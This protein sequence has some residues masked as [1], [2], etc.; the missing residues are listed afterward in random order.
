LKSNILV[1]FVDQ[2][3]WWHVST[4]RYNIIIKVYYTIK[5]NLLGSKNVSA[6]FEYPFGPMTLVDLH[7]H[8]RVK[9]KKIE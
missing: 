3:S 7:V 4:I 9:K 8:L 2:L 5:V 1:Q 6:V